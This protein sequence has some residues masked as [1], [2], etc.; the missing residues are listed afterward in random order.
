MMLHSA[1]L[2][3]IAQP[4]LRRAAGMP[5]APRALGM[6]PGAKPCILG[7]PRVPALSRGEVQARA[8]LAG[9]GSPACCS[10]VEWV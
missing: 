4:R 10:L 9:R 1:G 3:P 5:R 2:P 6:T 8:I 7:I